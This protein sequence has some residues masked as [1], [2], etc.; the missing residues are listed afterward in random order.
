MQPGNKIQLVSTEEH[1]ACE[2]P[3]FFSCDQFTPIC[4]FRWQNLDFLCARQIS[5][6]S[7]K[8]KAKR[9]PC[10]KI[11]S[12]F[13]GNEGR[14][15]SWRPW[16]HLSCLCVVTGIN[17]GSYYAIGTLLN[18]IILSYF[19]VSPSECVCVSFRWSLVEFQHK[20]S[21][22]HM[23]KRHHSLG[24]RMCV[25]PGND[26]RGEWRKVRENEIDKKRHFALFKRTE[27]RV[28]SFCRT[29]KR[30]LGW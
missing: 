13:G 29:E 22:F 18:P 5:V 28:C 8:Q 12:S 27:T 20:K 6:G 23:Q 26:G 17:T 14:C 4:L 7:A 2:P 9:I 10:W 15:H 24:N 11:S 3:F 1:K 30:M 21:P 16:S 25:W 19:E